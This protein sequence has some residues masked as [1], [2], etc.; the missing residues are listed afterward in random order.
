[1]NGG[2]DRELNIRFIVGF[3]IVLTAIT[4]GMAALMWT[5]SSL[6]R[7]RLE[8][9]DPAPPTLP[10]A[11]VQPEPPEP[12]LQTDPEEDMT[13]MRTE[14]ERLLSTYDWV[15][16]EG[17]IARVPIAR[18]IELMATQAPPEAEN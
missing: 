15:D 3:A 4:V 18:A 9:R 16:R 1:M 12:R 6:L 8:A 7:G 10:A 2:L 5:T 13:L 17:G 14:E 11:R